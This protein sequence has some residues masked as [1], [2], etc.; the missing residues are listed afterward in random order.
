MQTKSGKERRRTARIPVDA[1]LLYRAVGMDDFEL[2]HVLNVSTLSLEILL[3]RALPESTVVTIA[4]RPEGASQQYYRVVGEVKR[5]QQREG[6]W[7]HVIT[8]STERPWSPM[9]IYDVV[10]STFDPAPKSPVEEYETAC[11]KGQYSDLK[12]CRANLEAWEAS[13]LPSRPVGLE[14]VRGRASSIP[15]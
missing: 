1:V 2:C 14:N 13:I 8:A 4:V 7:M 9:F 11:R 6:G 3:D 10:C 15:A 5:A 12:G